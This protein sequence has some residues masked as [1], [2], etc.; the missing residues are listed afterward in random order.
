MLKVIKKYLTG[1]I[2]CFDK[3]GCPVRVERFGALDVKG[4]FY[5]CKKADL[6]KFKLQEQELAVKLMREQ[7]LKVCIVYMN[8]RTCISCINLYPVGAG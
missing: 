4:V 8:I 6:E 2:G 5:S 3:E 7:S 1:G